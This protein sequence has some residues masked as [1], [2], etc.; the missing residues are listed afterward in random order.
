MKCCSNTYNQP[1]G[2]AIRVRVHDVQ[3]Q[4]LI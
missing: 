3:V 2:F 1:A 4:N